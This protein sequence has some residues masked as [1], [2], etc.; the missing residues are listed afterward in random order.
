MKR[1]EILFL[2]QLVKSLSESEEKLEEAYGKRQYENFN[3]VKK[4]MLRIQNE[5]S[6]IIK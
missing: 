6:K 2:N 3:N 5:I 1:D 4:V